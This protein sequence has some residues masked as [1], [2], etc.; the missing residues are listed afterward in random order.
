MNTFG[1]PK[2]S[3]FI[4]NQFE[5][6]HLHYWLNK[7]EH[8]YHDENKILLLMRFS[9]IKYEKTNLHECCVTLRKWQKRQTLELEIAS[10]FKSLTFC[11]HV[12]QSDPFLIEV[13]DI[14]IFLKELALFVMYSFHDE[15]YYQI[16]SHNPFEKNK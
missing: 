16:I 3:I 11:R 13:S 9:F 1:T 6:T 7:Q 12:K 4:I 8:N 2:N 5:Y 14:N 10:Y 15:R